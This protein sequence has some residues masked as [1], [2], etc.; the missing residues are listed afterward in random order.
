VEESIV[1]NVTDGIQSP[2]TTSS[3]KASMNFLGK[4]SGKKLLMVVVV[5]LLFVGI[6]SAP[7]HAAPLH[8]PASATHYGNGH[9]VVYVRTHFRNYNP[10]AM[11]C[12]HRRRMM[13]MK[14]SIMKWRSSMT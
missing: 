5:A 13:S 11:A 12:K 14:I 6:L 1:V 2:P 7:A 8:H 9:K 10:V 4:K 3:R